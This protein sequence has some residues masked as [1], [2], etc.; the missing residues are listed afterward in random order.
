MTQNEE[1]VKRIKESAR[2]YK[3]WENSLD[4]VL[5]DLHT[6]EDPMTGNKSR[7]IIAETLLRLPKRIKRKVLD[8]IIFVVSTPRHNGIVC[9]AYFT[10]IIKTKDL[11]PTKG[12]TCSIEILQPLIFLNFGSRSKSKKMDMTAHEIA[13]FILGHHRS[14]ISLK[15]VKVNKA[16][17]EADDLIEK[18][19]FK[20][21]RK[22]YKIKHCK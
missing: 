6:W 19:G 1:L 3:E 16:E 20:R 18:W 13:H 15:G 2:Q 12:K 14:L 17:K 21:C 9:N 7:L 10:K 4:G 11:K 22:S 8:E 5:Y